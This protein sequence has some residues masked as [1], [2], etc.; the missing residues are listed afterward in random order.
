M[1][2]SEVEEGAGRIGKAPRVRI[3]TQDTQSAMALTL[4]TRLLVPTKFRSFAVF[5]LRNM[6]N[7]I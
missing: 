6:N 3:R 2:G 7:G 5:I 1:T 4:P